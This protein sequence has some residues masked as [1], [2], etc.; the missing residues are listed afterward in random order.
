[1]PRPK[2]AQTERSR[3]KS[4]KHRLYWRPGEP[5]DLDDLKEE[6][7]EVDQQVPGQIQSL[8][9]KAELTHERLKALLASEQYQEDVTQPFKVADQQATQIIEGR[10]GNRKHIQ[11]LQWFFALMRRKRLL[12]RLSAIK[13]ALELVNGLLEEEE[14]LTQ[15]FLTA[16]QVKQSSSIPQTHADP[17]QTRISL[18]KEEERRQGIDEPLTEIITSAKQ[19]RQLLTHFEERL[20]E[21]RRHL[22]LYNGWFEV[23]YVPKRHYK[24]T[25]ITYAEALEQEQ[26]RKI[27]IPDR[28]VQALHPEVAR[29]LRLS[30]QPKDMPKD[31]RDEIY[32]ITQEGPYVRYRWREQGHIYTIS[33]GLLDDYPPYPFVPS[34][35]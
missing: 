32:D 4:K 27:P 24:S 10:F 28:I 6:V 31:L 3:A 21:L 8:L 19:S 11:H 34:G 29:H 13:A 35:F 25:L 15:E 12:G 30:I 18:T 26:Q 17:A 23:F 5:H 14:T 2:Q 7:L 33:L 9:S 1:M 20:P 22:S 16:L